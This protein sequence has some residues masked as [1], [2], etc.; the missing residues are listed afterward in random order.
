MGTNLWDSRACAANMLH[1]NLPNSS[2]LA[3]V[4]DLVCMLTVQQSKAPLV[5]AISTQL[6]PVLG[7]ASLELI[8]ANCC[9]H[10]VPSDCSCE[11]SLAG[12]S[13]CLNSV[14]VDNQTFDISS[15]MDSSLARDVVCR[16][17]AVQRLI[18]FS[19]PAQGSWRAGTELFICS[20]QEMGHLLSG[21]VSL[22]GNK[23]REVDE[24]EPWVPQ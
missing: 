11:C 20:R 24:C 5:H 23:L 22:R 8:T 9:R 1:T 18:I 6:V 12:L 10:V 4:L 21:L 7:T 19:L 2:G 14:Y 13:Y 3:K 16:A 17:K 15:K